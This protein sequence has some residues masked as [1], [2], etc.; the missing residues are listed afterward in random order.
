MPRFTLIPLDERPVN[1]RYSQLIAQVANLAFDATQ[2]PRPSGERVA[3]LIAAIHAQSRLVLADVT[4]LE[5][6]HSAQASGADFIALTLNSYTEE[7]AD[8]GTPDF[9]LICAM[10]SQLRVPM[11][12]EGH[13]RT[14]QQPRQA[15]GRGALAV[16]VGSGITRPQIITAHFVRQLCA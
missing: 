11:I 13:I 5:E 9:A 16:V 12:A 1:A 7:T 8:N 6:A 10:A 15:L 3:D 4:T 14:P 2:H